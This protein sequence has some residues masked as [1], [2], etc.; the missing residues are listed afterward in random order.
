MKTYI[1]IETQEEC[2]KTIEYLKEEGLVY[3]NNNTFQGR[4]EYFQK[5]YPK[6]FASGEYGIC[7]YENSNDTYRLD[8]VSVI[9]VKTNTKDY[10]YLQFKDLVFKPKVQDLLDVLDKLELKLNDKN[11]SQI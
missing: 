11:L 1:Q 9:T 6:Q 2:S 3:E 10:H 4:M 7:I 8:I 5:V